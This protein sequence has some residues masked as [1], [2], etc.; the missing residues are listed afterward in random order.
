[1][2]AILFYSKYSRFCKELNH[3]VDI[4]DVFSAHV[5]VDNSVTRDK[6]KHIVTSVPSVVLI[7]EKKVLKVI[8]GR[9]EILT[10]VYTQI[11]DTAP[12]PRV[13][14]PLHVAQS[15]QPIQTTPLVAQ[16]AQAQ[17]L[18]VAQSAQP[19]QALQQPPQEPLRVAPQEQPQATTSLLEATTSLLQQ[20][21]AVPVE[22]SAERARE[23]YAEFMKRQKAEPA[24]FSLQPTQM[25]AQQNT[26]KKEDLLAKAHAMKQQQD[27]II[28]QSQYS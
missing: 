15:A 13:A 9:D 2:E 12:P 8:N 1:M 11:Q 7:Y 16:S 25:P 17:P 28:G 24:P 6:I 3:R 27:A 18:H 26:A 10:W 5:C 22:K 21:P 14:Q 4:D 19:P 23:E 20:P